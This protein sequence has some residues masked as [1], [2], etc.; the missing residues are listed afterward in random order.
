MGSLSE[1]DRARRL[2]YRDLRSRAASV[3]RCAGSRDVWGKDRDYE[4]AGGGSQVARR[5][6]DTLL[7]SL[8][9]GWP[10]WCDNRYESNVTRSESLLDHLSEPV[11]PAPGGSAKQARKRSPRRS[12]TVLIHQKGWQRCLRLAAHLR[13]SSL[14]RRPLRLPAACRPRR[15][16]MPRPPRPRLPPR[17][18]RRSPP[19]LRQPHLRP[20][21]RQ[22]LS[23]R[24]EKLKC[25]SRRS[26]P[27]CA[28]YPHPR[29]QV[30]RR[31]SACFPHPQRHCRP[32]P[33]SGDPIG[34]SYR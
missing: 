22:P 16:Q 28:P 4:G 1:R 32:E 27:P 21:P 7:R 29:P 10:L 13:A 31:A 33:D 34:D 25:P 6:P 8:L 17:S 11:L 30:P 18:S 5:K 3:R 19:L 9:C 15:C 12:V 24:R 20:R 23:A 2:L 14:P 26:Q